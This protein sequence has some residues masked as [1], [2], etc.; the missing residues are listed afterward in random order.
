MRPKILLLFL[1]GWVG[2]V[3]AQKNNDKDIAETEFK[4]LNEVFSKYLNLY[5]TTNEQLKK[6]N[7]EFSG[8]SDDAHLKKI[9][10]LYKE[11]KAYNDTL[12][13]KYQL[14]LNYKG[15]FMDKG[16]KETDIDSWF[17]YKDQNFI[18]SAETATDTN[19]YMYFGENKVLKED[20]L[21]DKNDE[22]SQILRSVINNKGKKV[23]LEILL[24]L[25]IKKNFIFI[26]M[27]KKE[28]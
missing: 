1:L 18:K 6:N 7:L 11:A 25:E 8:K 17:G 26:S 10:D 9:Q 19:V 20:I 12:A 4:N 13:V 27:L 24:Y 16:V 14:F 5:N 23:I 2:M 3:S 21:K 15:V 22:A 28:K